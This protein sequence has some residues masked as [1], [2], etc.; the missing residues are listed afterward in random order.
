MKN[1]YSKT[2]GLKWVCYP[3]NSMYRIF[4]MV[5]TEMYVDGKRIRY[6]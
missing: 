1:K 6:G 5:E 2:Y 4:N 3:K